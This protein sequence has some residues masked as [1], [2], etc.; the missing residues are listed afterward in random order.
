MVGFF[1]G[2]TQVVPR[3]AMREAVKASVPAGTEELNLKAFDK[4]LEYADRATGQPEA[5]VA[6]S[7]LAEVTA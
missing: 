7:E 6:E 4:G 2:V 5:K 1:T 3:D